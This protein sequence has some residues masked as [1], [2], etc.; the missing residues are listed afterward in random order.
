MRNIYRIV[1][2]IVSAPFTTEIKSQR[3]ILLYAKRYKLRQRIIL[4]RR[5]T[6]LCSG[7]R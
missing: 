3:S 7:Y 4:N 5:L 6:R 2:F 1:N